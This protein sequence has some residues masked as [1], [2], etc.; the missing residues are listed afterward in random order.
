MWDLEGTS[1]CAHWPLCGLARVRICTCA[2]WHICGLAKVRTGTC[3]DPYMCGL[4]QVCSGTC[5]DWDMC[6]VP[7]RS[8]A[9]GPR[10]GVRF[11]CIFLFLSA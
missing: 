9:M 8:V 7:P 2:I 3:A 11:Q 4:T 5:A 10:W 1:T 6:E